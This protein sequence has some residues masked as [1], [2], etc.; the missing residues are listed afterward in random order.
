MEFILSIFRKHKKESLRQIYCKLYG[1]WYDLSVFAD[2]HPGGKKILE[3]YH[4]EDIT[5]V[6]ESLSVHEYV[7]IESLEKYKIK[8]YS[9]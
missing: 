5:D 4:L 7:N 1:T 6:F 3:K 2:S 8:K 9:V